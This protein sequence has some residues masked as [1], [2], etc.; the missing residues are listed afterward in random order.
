MTRA[1]LESLIRTRP[2][3]E[4]TL[5]RSQGR[6]FHARHQVRYRVAACG[7]RWGKTRLGNTELIVAAGE[8]PGLYWYVA[9]TIKD[10]RE[11]AWHPPN[12]IGIRDMV[13][14]TWLKRTPNES[15]LEIEL[16]NGSQIILKGADDPNTLRGRGI[17]GLVIDEYADIKPEAWDETLQ[18]SLLDSGGWALFLGTVRGFD[19]FY[20][21]WQQGQDPAFPEWASWK[22]RTA[23]APHIDRAALESLRRQ[24]EKRGQLAL[25][26]QEFEASFEAQA[27]YILGALWR[28]THTVT[29]DD[30]VLLRQGYAVGD[31]LPWHVLDD[32]QWLPPPSAR[33]YASVDWG[34]GVPWAAHVH[35]VLGDGHIRTFREHYATHVPDHEQAAR[36]KATF[37]ELVARGL[38]PPEWI[39]M[40]PAMWASRQDVGRT[41]SIADI[42]RVELG[43]YGA[44]IR[45]G[46]SG[47][48]ARLSRPQRWMEALETSPDG[49]P[50]WS[51]TAACP[52]LI[53]TVPTVPWDKTDL[54]VE[55]D[56]S[57]SHA[58][59]GT[60][61]FFEARPVAGARVQVDPYQKLDPLSRRYWQE[62][63]RAEAVRSR[64]GRVTPGALNI[65]R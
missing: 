1:P 44:V 11:I 47:R 3:R 41:Q 15:R 61:R 52:E 21:L 59:E 42:Y 55:D 34:F 62:E 63:D 28:T 16:K 56:A 45:P 5:H 9:P 64:K 22:F 6:I 51:V 23:E 12:G 8:T 20:A 65:M 26:R 58:Y 19:H 29:P 18:P 30:R 10:A 4:L 25:F 43:P 32:R 14:P 37:D 36:L 50:W 13:P 53:R 48:P 27:G 57:E 33:L 17:R 49:F 2:T 38:P 46:A 39:V 24:Y 31:T 7:R 35:A 40:D 60:G 54:E